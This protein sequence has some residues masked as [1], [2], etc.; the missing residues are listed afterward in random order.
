MGKPM[1]WQKKKS[2]HMQKE[3][4]FLKTGLTINPSAQEQIKWGKPSQ[5]LFTHQMG[6]TLS[7]F[8][9]PDGENLAKFYL[10]TKWEATRGKRH[11]KSFL[12][13]H[14]HTNVHFQSDEKKTHKSFETGKALK[15]S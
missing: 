7:N 10:L 8:Y 4:Y 6:K 5:V 15:S 12:R 3:V 11:A 2:R 9:S 14:M 1:G 13:I